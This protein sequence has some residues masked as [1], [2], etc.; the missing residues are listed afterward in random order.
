MALPYPVK[1]IPRDDGSFFATHPDLVG[2]TAQGKSADEALENLRFS[3]E[4]WIETRLEG[5]LA[6]PV[7]SPEDDFSGKVLLRMSSRLHA[8]LSDAASNQNLSLNQLINNALSEYIGGTA[9]HRQVL[10]I[11]HELRSSFERVSAPPQIPFL[12]APVNLTVDLS[13][14]TSL[15]QQFGLPKRASRRSMLTL[16]QTS[17]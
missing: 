13:A 12:F 16:G 8:A 5:G 6:V 4:L 3:R 2:C 1:L 17:Q 14:D 10:E 7:P 11:N 15:D 9:M